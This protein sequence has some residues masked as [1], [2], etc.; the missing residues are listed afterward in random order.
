MTEDQTRNPFR[1]PAASLDVPPPDKGPQP[2]R[3]RLAS[4]I[5]WASAVL[6]V[7]L[8]FAPWVGL[9]PILPGETPLTDGFSAFFNFALLGL[10]AQK[11]ALG[12][13]WARWLMLVIWTFG[14]LSLGSMMLL[15]PAVSKILSGIRLL[16]AIV[17]TALQMAVVMLVFT[18]EARPWF[19][20]SR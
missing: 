9:A 10:F 2:A 16:G 3:V 15:V 7:I 19:R 6:N 1:P 14:F 8:A 5:L 12:R 17:Q 20:A 18:G 13:N 11:I 4:R